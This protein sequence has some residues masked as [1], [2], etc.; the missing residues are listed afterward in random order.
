M[1]DGSAKR[2]L[3]KSD[4]DWTHNACMCYKSWT[5]YA[6][7]YKEAADR[8]T[9][10]VMQDRFMLDVLVYPIVFLYRH[11]LELRLK[12]IIDQG[13]KLVEELIEL[14]HRHDLMTLWTHA[15]NIVLRI[16]PKT[17]RTELQEITS[18]VREFHRVDPASMTFRYGSDKK[19]S[20]N[21]PDDIS[22]INIRNMRDQ[23]E[24]VAVHVDGAA[25]GIGHMLG[26]IGQ[27]P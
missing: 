12:E 16:W 1:D 14:P 19:G 23:L 15:T 9:Q 25:F 11:W 17:D 22:H 7:G 20:D 27:N 4:D 13:Q 3:F 5:A 10:S 6:D 8:L 21:L 26:E 2:V 18:I 24:K